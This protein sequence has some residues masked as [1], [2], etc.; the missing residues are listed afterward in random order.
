MWL[1]NEAQPFIINH[2]IGRKSS[3]KQILNWIQGNQQKKAERFGLLYEKCCYKS[4]V[5]KVKASLLLADVNHLSVNAAH[6]IIKL[7]AMQAKTTFWMFSLRKIALYKFSCSNKSTKK[8]KLFACCYCC[9][10][11]CISHWMLLR[12]LVKCIWHFSLFFSLGL[13]DYRSVCSF[14]RSISLCCISFVGKM[15]PFRLLRARV[16]VCVWQVHLLRQ[17]FSAC[18]Y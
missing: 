2:I 9:C 8:S 1:L 14:I 16:C 11:Y 7:M 15:L 17:Q 12:F 4:V 5:A 13:T 6:Y 10:C 3:F 18:K